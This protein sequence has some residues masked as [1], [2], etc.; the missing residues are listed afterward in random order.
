M[1]GSALAGSE[2]SWSDSG[3]D[4]TPDTSFTISS[5]FL[6]ECF[7]QNSNEESFRLKRNWN[8]QRF[9]IVD[10]RYELNKRLNEQKVSDPESL[11][12]SRRNTTS[13][14]TQTELQSRLK[15]RLSI[16]FGVVGETSCRTLFNS[17]TWKIL[18]TAWSG[19]HI[20]WC[21]KVLAPFLISYFFVCLSYIN[22]SH[23]KQNTKITQVNP[24]Y[25]FVKGVYY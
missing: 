9:S 2:V 11:K 25:S 4:S 18:L 17:S 13:S 12:T 20:Q 1:P 15:W 3:Q 6:E 14:A 24:K 22:V 21:E 19:N 10:I 8:E 7:E 23:H 5:R 16:S